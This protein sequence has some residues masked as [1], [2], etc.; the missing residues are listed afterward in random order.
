MHRKLE[1]TKFKK[2]NLQKISNFKK[3]LNLKFYNFKHLTKSK[4]C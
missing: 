2:L 4:N 1:V 3:M